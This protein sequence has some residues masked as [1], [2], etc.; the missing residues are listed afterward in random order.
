M[1]NFNNATAIN[2]VSANLTD[3]ANV[4]S[5]LEMRGGDPGQHG[6]VSPVEA[7]YWL[8]PGASL[9]GCQNLHKH[10]YVT[11]AKEASAEPA[12]GIKAA[13]PG[14]HP[15]LLPSRSPAGTGRVERRQR[16]IQSTGQQ[17]HAE[18]GLQQT[19]RRPLR[20]V[21]FRTAFLG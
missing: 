14:S 3:S 18:P 21:S 17:L 13:A 11:S 2:N 20:V 10:F 9:H 7:S 8:K 15:C 1:R 19:G 6:A 4:A 12:T 16:A 5:I